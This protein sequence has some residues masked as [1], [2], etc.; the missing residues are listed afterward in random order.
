[1]TLIVKHNEIQRHFRRFLSLGLDEQTS[2]LN[3]YHVAEEPER[4]SLQ[5]IT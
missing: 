1:M 5:Q 4:Q 2:I 3:N